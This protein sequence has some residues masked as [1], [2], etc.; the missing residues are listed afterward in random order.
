MLFEINTPRGQRDIVLPGGPGPLTDRGRKST[1]K[2]PPPPRI[3]G[4]AEAR[5]E[6][7]H[8]YREGATGPNEN[9]AKVGH[10]GSKAGSRD[11]LFN[12]ATAYTSRERL[13]IQC[14]AWCVAVLSMQPLPNYSGL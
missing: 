13:Q 9:Y 4:T 6:I 12:S 8:A 1:F 3:S 10:R 7:L 2:F 11:L 14:F 5:L